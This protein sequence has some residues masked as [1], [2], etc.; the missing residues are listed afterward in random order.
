MTTFEKVKR[1]I[2]RDMREIPVH[3]ETTWADIMIRNTC[4][5]KEIEEQKKLWNWL[6]NPNEDSPPCTFM[7]VDKDRKIVV[8][9]FQKMTIKDEGD[10]KTD[11]YTLNIKN[12][13]IRNGNVC[14]IKTTSGRCTE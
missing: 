4:Q 10:E 9:E 13:T 1:N 12:E 8:E 5:M 14:Y 2:L 6:V 7:S 3:S 11:T